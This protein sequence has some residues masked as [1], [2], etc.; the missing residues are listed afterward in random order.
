MFAVCVFSPVNSLLT[1]WKFISLKVCQ[2]ATI[3]CLHLVVANWLIPSFYCFIAILY[4]IKQCE[5]HLQ[6]SAVDSSSFPSE[7]I[8]RLQQQNSTLRAVVAEMRKEMEN[9]SQQMPKAQSQTTNPEPSTAGTRG[10][11]TNKETILIISVT[12]FLHFQECL[13][14]FPYLLGKSH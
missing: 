9:L 10:L 11:Q 4:N 5:L 14:L 3:S 12:Y 13:N 1:D 6:A 7:E 2:H 8:R